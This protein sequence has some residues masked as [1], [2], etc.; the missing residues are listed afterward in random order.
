MVNRVYDEYIQK[1][2]IF[3]YPLL[4]IKKGSEAV[5]IE[6]YVSWTGVFD[7]S[8]MKY[9]CIYH[10]RDDDTFKRFEKVKLTGNKLF[11]AYYETVDGNGAYV[12][13][14]SEYKSDWNHFIDGKYTLLSSNTKNAILKFFMT[15]KSNYHQINSYLNP[16]IY[17]EQYANLL[18]VSEKLLR[19]VGEL[20]SKPDL[21]KETLIAEIKSISLFH[22]F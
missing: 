18:N 12:F 6:S 16:E 8:E 4:D 20:C 22:H 7:S 13:D 17:F 19:D 3:I 21:D 1:S 2:R 11:H 9:V 15:N 5:P 10:L 14:M